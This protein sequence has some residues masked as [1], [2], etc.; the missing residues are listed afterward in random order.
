[1]IE[2]D[3]E[4]LPTSGGPTQT[5]A[6]PALAFRAVLGSD[7]NLQLAVVSWPREA[8]QETNHEWRPPRRRGIRGECIVMH[9][10]QV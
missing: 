6:T 5:G 7:K 4:L 8:R 3:G 9:A 1:V 10:V 2:P